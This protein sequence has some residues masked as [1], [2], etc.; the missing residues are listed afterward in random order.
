[1]YE[2]LAKLDRRWVFLLMFAAVALPILFNVRFPEEP[3][4]MV[5]EVHNAIEEL[6]DGSLVLM[7]FDYDP[8]SA[9]EL[10]PMAAAFIRHCAEKHH[11]MLFMTL[12]SPGVPLLN[13]NVKMLQNE[14]PEYQVGRDFVNFGFKPGLEGVIK[15]I[16][17]DL[18]AMFSTDVRGKS[19]SEMPLTQNIKNIQK[20]SMIVAVSAGSPGAKEWVQYAATPYD[21]PMVSGTTGV[22]T[23]LLYPYIPNQLAGVLGGIKAAAE[24]EQTL[25]DRYDD[26]KAKPQAQEGMRRMGPQLV[27]HMLII[28]LI[29]VGNTVYFIGRKK[30]DVR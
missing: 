10:Q 14:Y 13:S 23:P 19:L 20:V 3:S 12:W 16:V 22:Q 5:R 27:A 18:A 1:M 17:N 28:L 29:L 2:F 30:G 7:A 6:P 24:Y 15:V 4:P 25:L 9:G 11:K 21:I 26:L 8:A